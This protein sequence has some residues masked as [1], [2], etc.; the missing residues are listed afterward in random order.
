MYAFYSCLT[1]LWLTQVVFKCA[2]QI[3]LSWAPKASWI[4]WREVNKSCT[5]KLNTVVPCKKKHQIHMQIQERDVSASPSTSERN[6][7]GVGPAE[8]TMGWKL[9]LPL[10]RLPWT[11]REKVWRYRDK[12]SWVL[13]G[14]DSQQV[15]G[16][17][18]P[19]KEHSIPPT[20][21]ILSVPGWCIWI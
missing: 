10:K 3:N 17:C 11:D 16:Y 20:H 21:F 14:L 19:S 18:H 7:K 6:R 5:S 9:F 2:L 4:V 13:K 1:A 8:D 15:R 12:E